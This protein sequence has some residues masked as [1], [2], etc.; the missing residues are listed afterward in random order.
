MKHM[1][2]NKAKT[3]TDTKKR[4]G[5]TPHPYKI[6]KEAMQKSDFPAKGGGPLAK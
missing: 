3:H 4:K 6:P 2:K 5:P 1:L